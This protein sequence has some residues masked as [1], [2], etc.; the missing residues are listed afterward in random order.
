MKIT[1][2]DLKRLK[3]QATTVA[4]VTRTASYTGVLSGWGGEWI[5][6]HTGHFQ[7][8]IPRKYIKRIAEIKNIWEE[9]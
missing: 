6:L 4:V 2:K 5:T 7:E 1:D 9:K 3:E 8:S